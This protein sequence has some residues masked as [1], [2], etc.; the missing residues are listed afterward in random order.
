MKNLGVKLLAAYLILTGVFPF[1]NLNSN[2]S[3]IILSILA[4]ASGILL[5]TNKGIKINKRTGIILLAV[6][7]ILDTLIPLFNLPIP[8]LHQI[9]AMLAIAAGIFLLI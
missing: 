6:W 1:I 7:L 4:I 3:G 9:L 8:F 2:A 5:I